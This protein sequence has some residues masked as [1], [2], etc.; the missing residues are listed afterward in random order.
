[1]FGVT[2][3]CVQGVHLP[4]LNVQLE[5]FMCVCVCVLCDQTILINQILYPAHSAILV[6]RDG[7][8]WS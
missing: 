6:E 1:M 3:G 8:G 5:T 7:Q 4:A 2:F